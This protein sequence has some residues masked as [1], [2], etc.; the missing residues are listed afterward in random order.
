[1][2][3]YL[4]WWLIKSVEHTY[5]LSHISSNRYVVVFVYNTNLYIWSIRQHTN[6]IRPHVSIWDMLHSTATVL[7]QYWFNK[8]I[9]SYQYKY[10]FFFSEATQITAYSK[11]PINSISGCLT[12]LGCHNPTN[13]ICCSTNVSKCVESGKT[14]HSLYH[15]IKLSFTFVCL[16]V[17][18]FFFF[19]QEKTT[20]QISKRFQS[21]L[22]VP[23]SGLHNMAWCLP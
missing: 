8:V 7:H 23:Y 22:R 19:S 17:F 14:V 13:H 6:L 4:L 2:V 3:R 5:L 15:I 1:M 9:K 18:F 11:T 10:R 20:H 16:T 12:E 21:I